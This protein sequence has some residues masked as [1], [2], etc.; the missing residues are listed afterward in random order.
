MAGN[1]LDQASEESRQNRLVR[2]VWKGLIVGVIVTLLILLC[3]LLGLFL[4]GPALP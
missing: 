3:S 1:N 4:F 2:M